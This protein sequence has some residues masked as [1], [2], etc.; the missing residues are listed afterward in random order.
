MM[1]T[2]YDIKPITKST[3]LGEL[4]LDILEQNANDNT[5]HLIQET[6]I[7][8]TSPDYAELFTVIL[9]NALGYYAQIS[10]SKVD[11]AIT[12]MIKKNELSIDAIPN[13]TID[14][15]NTRKQIMNT[16]LGICKQ[17]LKEYLRYYNILT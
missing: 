8:M 9:F 14:E 10:E 11:N 13:I 16:F 5:R 12:F 17:Q 4:F 2:I 1:N 6:R 15:K 3:T 7:L